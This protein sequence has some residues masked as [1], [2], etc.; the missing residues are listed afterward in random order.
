MIKLR[1]ENFGGLIFNTKNGVRLDLDQSGF[2][3]TKDFI[4]KRK[5]ALSKSQQIFLQDLCQKLNLNKT[6]SYSIQP[7]K[8]KKINYPFAVLNSPVLVDFQI[9]GKCNLACPHCYAQ[10]SSQGRHVPLKDIILV[11][12]QCRQAGVLEVALGGGE[13][14]IH[15]DFAKILKIATKK[16]LVVNLATNGKTMT[17]SL[18]RQ[19]AN[20]CGAVALSLEFI[21]AEF[22][23]RRGYDFAKFLNS[24]KLIKDSGLRL[25][26]Q[27]TVSA[28][29]LDK[30]ESIV[31]FLSPYQPY[32]VVFL[33]YKP[34]GRGE[35]FDS[36][37][38]NIKSRRILARLNQ[39]F[40]ILQQHQVKIGYDCCLG[41]L[42]TGIDRETGGEIYGCSALRE[43]V[44][45]DTG[46]NV[47]PCSF[48]KGGRLGNLKEQ[49]LLTIWHNHQAELFRQ[50]FLAKI[51]QN[52]VCKICPHKLTCLGGCPVFN[53][54]RCQKLSP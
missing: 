27:I 15:P 17:K 42:I 39:C 48:I 13:P 2:A 6:E 34:V 14:T 41:N 28:Q 23:K 32:G 38:F 5:I 11:L 36:P 22:K 26:F 20:Y 12:E 49:N 44:A 37:L 52:A 21:N 45:V 54:V 51:T 16:G 9:T 43:S 47:L 30:L 40:K 31:K 53:L 19:L 35:F 8:V 24:V 33:T 4:Q 50:Q 25:V 3:L 10:A 29:N 1:P 18:A 7:L 46:L